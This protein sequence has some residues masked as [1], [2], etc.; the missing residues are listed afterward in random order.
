VEPVRIPEDA[1]V[2]LEYNIALFYTGIQR[3]ASDILADQNKK[4]QDDDAEVV[5]RLIG[6]QG[7]RADHQ[8][9]F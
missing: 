9:L 3:K 1:L 4:T 7:D 6:D 5:D 2:E 8:A